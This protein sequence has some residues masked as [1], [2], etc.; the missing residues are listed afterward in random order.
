MKGEIMVKK[1]T[2]F[3]IVALAV[4]AFSYF[5]Q[6]SEIPKVTNRATVIYQAYD[7]IAPINKDRAPNPQFVNTPMK[8]EGQKIVG[9]V[10]IGPEIP[11][12]GLT[13]FYD[14]QF[15]GNQDH[16]LYRH[17][18]TV[19]HAVYMLSQDSLSVSPSRRVKYAFSSNNGT[20]WSDLGEV[21][22][23]RAGFPCGN[24]LA[25]GEASITS[26][27]L[28]SGGTLQTW[29]NYDLS[30]G[31]GVFSPVQGPDEYIWPIQARVTNNNMLVLGTSYR[32]TA[33][34]D[35][36]TISVF[37]T[38][39]HTFGPKIPLFTTAASNSN[40]SLAIASGPNGTGVVIVNAYRETGGNFGGSRIFNFKTT[41]NGSTWSASTVQY[42]PMIIQGD[43]ATSYVNG[44][45]DVIYDAAG[46]TYT[47]FN[48]LGF[49]GFFSEARLYVQKN[50][51]T[52]VLVAGGPTSPFNP[53]AEAMINTLNTQGFLGSLDHPCLS[54]SSDQQ[55]L[56]VSFSVLHQNDTLFGW[57]KAH[58]Y[59]SWAPLSNLS[60]WHAPVRISD[61]GPNSNDER[62]GSIATVTPLEGGYYSIY[63][64]YQ[65][66]AQPGSHTFD[67]APLS[68]S[69][70]VFRKIDDA[71]LIG[72]NNNQHVANEYKLYQNYPNP[73]NPATKIGYNLLRNSFVTLKLYDVL[74]RE[75][76]TIVSG[77]QTAG[78]KE[79]EFN[80][81]DLS[82]GIY[83]YTIETTEQGS[84]NI[85]KDTKKMILVK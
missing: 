30:P 21:P 64:S 73:F 42:N 16:Y 63:M 77:N 60:Q 34:T 82:S 71:T 76:R 43:T 37:N 19:M 55:Y 3:L 40:S 4:Y 59:Y 10:V 32:G 57:N 41:D 6:Q 52:P 1:T 83:F 44:A 80:A 38:T 48:T 56:F 23:I 53:I 20:T 47:A 28:E 27:Y 78:F 7:G 72:V 12:T 33:A 22:T 65:K 31:V 15:N 24:S 61:A 14:Y 67:N 49:T 46:N 26:H 84:G 2:L 51:E 70:L 50:S 85:F 9:D 11:I 8:F 54:V 18:S 45:T 69:W 17:S 13:G 36:T 25:T 58:M 68:R 66:D 79:I 81:S 74:G 5:G 35:T 39:S 62:Y 75:L 29:L